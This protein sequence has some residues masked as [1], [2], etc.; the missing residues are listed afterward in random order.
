MPS[1]LLAE[2]GETGQPLRLPG[3]RSFMRA[4]AAAGL[5]MLVVLL[6]A[7]R[8][9]LAAVAMAAVAQRSQGL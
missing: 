1:Q 6:E 2:M 3:R 5:L 9:E 4:A 7:A 8:V